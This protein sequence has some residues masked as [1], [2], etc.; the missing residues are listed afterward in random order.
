[1][2]QALKSE[3]ARLLIRQLQAER[4]LSQTD[5]SKLL[6]ISPSVVAHLLSGIRGIGARSID[7]I[8]QS[9]GLR[10]DYFFEDSIGDSPDYRDYLVGA[11]AS[12]ESGEHRLNLPA[13]DP[14]HWRE[15]LEHYPH[16]DE[17]AA[18][19]LESIK[20]FASPHH[21]VRSWV[22][23]MRLAEWL[24]EMRGRQSDD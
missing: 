8:R 1:M 6:G 4:G 5:V 23:W 18:S 3:R 24:R 20:G 17:L 9:M 22:D 15:F 16:V 2:S 13:P 7:E 10:A 11:K 19:D 14:P 12:S 21:Q